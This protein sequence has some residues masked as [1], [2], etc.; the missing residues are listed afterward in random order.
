MIIQEEMLDDLTLLQIVS[1]RTWVM[2]VTS[3]VRFAYKIM[4]WLSVSTY[5][6][7]NSGSC[8]IVNVAAETGIG[9]QKCCLQ[10][11]S[12]LTTFAKRLVHHGSIA[13]NS[14]HQEASIAR[15]G[16]KR[17]RTSARK[18]R[19]NAFE[20]AWFMC[21][22]PWWIGN[23]GENIQLDLYFWKNKNKQVNTFTPCRR[24]EAL[25]VNTTQLSF[26]ITHLCRVDSSTITL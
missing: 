25:P 4:F 10:R 8:N 20:F 7:I 3:N 13:E 15:Y 23:S 19:F 22:C 12:R 16:R 18:T 5:K 24:L 1:L 17:G 14:R 6:A 21:D 2:Y 11:C 26:Y 9:I